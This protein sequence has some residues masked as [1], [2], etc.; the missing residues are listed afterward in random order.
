MLTKHIWLERLIHP[1]FNEKFKEITTY[2][3]ENLTEDLTVPALC[4]RFH[5]SK[6]T[7]YGYFKENADVTVKTYVSNCRLAAAERLLLTT[8][9]PIYEVCERV[10]MEN[11]HSFCRLFKQKHDLSPLHYRKKAPRAISDERST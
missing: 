8:D 7:L 4:L 2:I 6:N 1:V 5:L 9:L 3:Q 10:G 11:S